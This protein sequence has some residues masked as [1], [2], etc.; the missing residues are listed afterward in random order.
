MFRT[1]LPVCLAAAILC[2]FTS[3]SGT[4]AEAGLE[5]SLEMDFNAIAAI[6]GIRVAAAKDVP[7]KSYTEDYGP[8]QVLEIIRPDQGPISVGRLMT[9]CSCLKATLAKRDFAQGERAFIEVRNVKPTQPQGA[10]YLV[11]ARLASPYAATLQYELYAKSDRAPA[12]QAPAAGG[13]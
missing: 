8:V 7:Q 1:T 5:S 3:L 12:A 2:F 4:A 10:T 11:F 6:D 13:Q 9:S